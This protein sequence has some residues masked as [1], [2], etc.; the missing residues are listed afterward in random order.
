MI[1]RV[2]R[3]AVTVVFKDRFFDILK[4]TFFGYCTTVPA[5]NPRYKFLDGLNSGIVTETETDF[6]VLVWCPRLLV[7]NKE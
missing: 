6:L 4:F 3:I 5:S 1:H 2:A 7:S